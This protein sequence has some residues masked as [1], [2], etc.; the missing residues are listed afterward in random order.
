MAEG[1]DLEFRVTGADT[2]A[3][4]VENLG[5]KI[6]DATAAERD[7]D[8]VTREVA[9]KLGQLSGAVGLVAREVGSE[10][11]GLL[12][13]LI[14]STAQFASMGA[15]LGPGGAVIGGL[16]GAAVGLRGVATAATHVRD[17][18]AALNRDTAIAMRG[19]AHAIGEG[20]EGGWTAAMAAAQAQIVE[21]ESTARGLRETA[22]STLVGLFDPNQALLARVELGRV[23]D[24]INTLR[25]R[26]SDLSEAASHATVRPS[27]GGAGMASFLGM[28]PLLAG[29]A[30]NE[31]P[32]S[33]SSGPSRRDELAEIY[34]QW[35][36]DEETYYR[37]RAVR[38]AERNRESM[39]AAMSAAHEHSAELFEIEESKATARLNRER[40]GYEAIEDLAREHAEHIREIEDESSENRKERYERERQ[41]GISRQEE[42]MG[43]GMGATKLLTNAIGEVISGAE[44][45]EEAFM[46]M[47]KGFL[48]MIS[49]YATLS[50]T[51]EYADAIAS[52]A[53][54]NWGAAAQHVAAGI[55]FTGLA[56]ATGIGAGAIN[57]G[58]ASV[59]RPEP[60]R[61]STRG[62][63]EGGGRG[64][65]DVIIHWNSPVVTAATTDELGGKLRLLLREAA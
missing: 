9:Q 46:G 58:G 53:S 42:M 13:G 33:R 39:D 7:F 28:D 44:S 52:A 63:G 56:V 5:E 32:P 64:G 15:A 25:S 31:P 16:A 54:N 19:I 45:G 2:G 26:I 60:A 18:L 36:T 34:R 6:Q 59:A 37:E 17:E 43:L 35:E 55:A 30:A 4:Q 3:R 61:P 21:L 51:R 14:G 49:E 24:Q 8:R 10:S 41:E 23:E 40:E 62:D 48:E 50:A 47:L 11:L 1:I 20:D 57:T 29:G 27:E 12:S 65:G 38:E 22:G